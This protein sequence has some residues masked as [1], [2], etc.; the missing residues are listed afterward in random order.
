MPVVLFTGYSV[1]QKRYHGALTTI[2]KIKISASIVI[3][4]ILPILVIWPTI[5]PKIVVTPSTERWIF[6]GLSFVL[7]AA[8]GL[9]GHMGGKLV[10]GNRK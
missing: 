9:A 4:L 8:V 7:L 6:M 3:V 5:Q 1:W 2:F 10:F